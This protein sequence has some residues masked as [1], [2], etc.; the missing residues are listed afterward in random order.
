[1]KTVTSR[2]ALAAMAL[3]LCLGLVACGGDGDEAVSSAQ[4]TPQAQA[5]Q[6]NL[7]CAP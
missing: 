1:M 2:H 4:L 3:L 5:V 6:P 7:K